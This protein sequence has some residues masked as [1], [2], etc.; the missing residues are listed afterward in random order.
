M[1]NMIY[2]SFPPFTSEGNSVVSSPS[3]PSM[4][5]LR[6]GVSHATGVSSIEVSGTVSTSMD[7]HSVDGSPVMVGESSIET[8][9]LE[10][11]LCP[12]LANDDE[13]GEFPRCVKVQVRQNMRKGVF[14]IPEDLFFTEE[15]L[16]SLFIL[17][18]DDAADYLGI[19]RTSLKKVCRRLG[20]RRWPYKKKIK[21]LERDAV[22]ADTSDMDVSGGV[23]VATD[24]SVCASDEMDVSL[25]GGGD[26]SM[27]HSI[28][29]PGATT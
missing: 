2:T 7:C 1:T 23:G 8:P 11:F 20:V 5:S 12:P 25:I 27:C 28:V 3:S 14:N 13:S 6:E 17:R 18:Q 15:N 10:N 16:R 22:A 26:V 24:V 29:E 21:V 9:C 19:S 4:P